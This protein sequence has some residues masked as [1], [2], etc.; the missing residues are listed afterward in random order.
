[1]QVRLIIADSDKHVIV[2]TS[3]IAIEH[4]FV[5]CHVKIKEE[6]L[7]DEQ[8][9]KTFRTINKWSST[10]WEHSAVNSLLC[11]IFGGQ[12][13]TNGACFLSI[14]SETSPDFVIQS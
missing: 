13:V 1:M 14:K 7:K 12:N 3:E 2:R 6:E 9:E 11:T 8:I 4:T 10:L 5:L